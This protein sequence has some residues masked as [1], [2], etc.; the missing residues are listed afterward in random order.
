MK[1]QTWRGVAWPAGRRLRWRRRLLTHT[2]LRQIRMKTQFRSHRSRRH[3]LPSGCDRPPRVVFL[4][5]H[6][7]LLADLH[8]HRLRLYTLG[9]FGPTGTSLFVLVGPCTT[10]MRTALRNSLAQ[11]FSTKASW[12]F[13]PA[14]LWVRTLDFAVES[15]RSL[16]T[17]LRCRPPDLWAIVRHCDRR[18]WDHSIGGGQHLRMCFGIFLIRDVPCCLCVCTGVCFV[19]ARISL[20]LP[21][22]L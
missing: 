9:S 14:R 13:P 21:G 15:L 3:L 1:S 8:S 17:G 22:A 4:G 6:T 7:T 5:S 11:S 18:A 10:A 19:C 2:P 16:P 12:Q 20:S